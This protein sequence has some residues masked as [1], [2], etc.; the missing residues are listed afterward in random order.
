M[1]ILNKIVLATIV[2]NLL[3]LVGMG[4]GIAPLGLI[5]VFLFSSLMEGDLHLSL[6][7][8]YDS[9]AEACA[10]L[11]LIGQ[12]VLFISMFTTRNPKLYLVIAGLSILLFAFLVLTFGLTPGT[13]EPGT[14]WLAIPFL[15]TAVRL[16]VLFITRSKDPAFLL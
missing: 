1:S 6:M 9:R 15:Y 12:I 4:H 3:I 13:S 2:C 5:E 11:S 14:V 16:I 10:G 8:T 7:G